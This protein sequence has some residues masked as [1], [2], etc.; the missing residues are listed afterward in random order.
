MGNETANGR[1]G[2]GG[3]IEQLAPLAKLLPRGEFSAGWRV[4]WVR[5]VPGRAAD[6]SISDGA[7]DVVVRLSPRSD[8]KALSR[9]VSP[10]LAAPSRSA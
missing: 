9:K 1:D 5:P 7:G 8:A 6:V 3:L 2:S 4:A 10:E